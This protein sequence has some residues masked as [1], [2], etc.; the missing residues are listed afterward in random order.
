[1]K[2]NS[3]INEEYLTM[4]ELCERIKYKKQTIYNLIYKDEFILGKHYLK[5]SLRK[6]LFKWTEI[7]KWM[8]DT[9]HYPIPMNKTENDEICT[10]E[11]IVNKTDALKNCKI[12]I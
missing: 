4:D 3:K 5:P 8:G 6:I 1:M 12:T 9:A 11:N 7:L 2:N 10:S